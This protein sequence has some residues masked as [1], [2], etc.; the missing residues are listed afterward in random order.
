MKYHNTILET[1]GHTPLVK[2]NKVTAGIKPIVLAKAE[3]FNPGGS[4]KDRPA[5]KMIDEAEKMGLL[6]PGG[7]IIEPTSGNTGTGLAQIAAV[8]GYRCILVV[9]DKV[10]SEKINRLLRA[11]PLGNDDASGPHADGL[12]GPTDYDVRGL[13]APGR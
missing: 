2:L 6:K 11:F 10:A 7:T 4:V 5:G 3:F 9:P 1:V 8:R 12:N 13:A